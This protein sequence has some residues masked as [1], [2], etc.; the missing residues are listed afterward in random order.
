[1]RTADGRF[2]LAFNGEIYNYV[3]LRDEL[4]RRGVQFRTH[5]DTEVLLELLAREGQAALDRLVGM[6]A[7]ALHDRQD[8]SVLLVR[9][10][11]GV[12]PLYYAVTPDGELVFGSEIKALL[13]H[14]S[15]T[16]RRDDSSLQQYLTFQFCLAEATLFKGHS[17]G[18]ARLPRA[19][20]TR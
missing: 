6:F 10:H 14:P 1:M 4:A 3:E 16:A 20:D 12:K 7:F 17:Q 18:R 15:I 13:R 2:T 11:F 9:D 5:S 8:D 19:L